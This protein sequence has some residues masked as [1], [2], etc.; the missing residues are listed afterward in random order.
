MFN[1][2]DKI[3]RVFNR[4]RAETYAEIEKEL[5][6]SPHTCQIIKDII[7]K[8]TNTAWDR[9]TFDFGEKE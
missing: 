9:I 8:T 2:Q 7:K 5:N 4:L 3:N 6:N 1:N